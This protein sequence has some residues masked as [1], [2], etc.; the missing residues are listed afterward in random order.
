MKGDSEIR[1]NTT[2]SSQYLGNR[3]DRRF[4]RIRTVRYRSHLEYHDFYYASSQKAVAE[5]TSLN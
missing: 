2:A 4:S 1:G 3:R 5:T